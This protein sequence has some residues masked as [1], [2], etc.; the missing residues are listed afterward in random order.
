MP[1]AHQAEDNSPPNDPTKQPCVAGCI[2]LKGICALGWI[3]VV[4]VYQDRLS[5]SSRATLN[6]PCLRTGLV[7]K[8]MRM[9]QKDRLFH[10]N[11]DQLGIIS[12][13]EIPAAG[14]LYYRPE[15]SSRKAKQNGLKRDNT[16][17]S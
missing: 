12:P 7:V 4:W 8:Q 14:F 5:D 2:D 11:G 6:N 17:L 10:R 16:V 9:L 13:K 1:F 3:Q 15:S